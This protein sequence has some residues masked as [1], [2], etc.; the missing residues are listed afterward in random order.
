MFLLLIY[1]FLIWVY[2]GEEVISCIGSIF[3]VFLFISFLFMLIAF[4]KAVWMAV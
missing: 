1:L 4:I 2:S 3:M